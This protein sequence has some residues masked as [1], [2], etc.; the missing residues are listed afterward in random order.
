M[1]RIILIINYKSKNTFKNFKLKE[2]KCNMKFTHKIHQALCYAAL[3]HQGQKRKS[4]SVPYIMHPLAVAWILSQYSN[5]QDLIIAGLLH[6]VIEDTKGY[7]RSRLQKLFGK[8]V[9]KI[10]QEVTGVGR[11]SM[12]KKQKVNTWQKRKEK[13]LKKLNTAS[14]EAL[15]ICCADKIH[16]LISYIEGFQ[17]H[18][19]KFWRDFDAPKEKEIWFKNEVF[20]ILNKRLKNQNILREYRKVLKQ[21]NKVIK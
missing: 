8:K 15:L 5:N 17:Q 2:F 4:S 11:P 9:F 21:A 10:V 1:V 3:L 16:N 18:R 20:K 19:E 13:Y 6:D 14:Q 7:S 12:T